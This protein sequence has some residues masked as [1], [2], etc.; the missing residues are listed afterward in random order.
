MQ[1]LLLHLLQEND[2]VSHKV[3]E[4]VHRSPGYQRAIREYDAVALRVRE[5]L[6]Y[7]LLDAYE[8]AFLRLAIYENRAFYAVG[9]GLREEM[10]RLWLER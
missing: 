5:L 6:G 4:L 7:E 9:L 10:A 3:H 2:Q 1:D 8:A